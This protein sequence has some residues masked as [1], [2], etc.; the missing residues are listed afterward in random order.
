ME[1]VLVVVY[2]QGGVSMRL[3]RTLAWQCGCQLGQVVD[4]RPREGLPGLLRSVYETALRASPPVGYRGPNP[5]DFRTV[6]VV[7]PLWMLRIAS[8]MRTFLRQ[9]AMRLG[10][11]VLVTTSIEPH[12]PVDPAAEIGR[13]TGRPPLLCAS[14]AR[15]EVLRGCAGRLARFGSLVAMC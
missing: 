9:E 6:V 1:P 13:L 15:G 10:R 4:L 7:S 5:A 2:S 8:P 12:D 3:A 11:I 14:F